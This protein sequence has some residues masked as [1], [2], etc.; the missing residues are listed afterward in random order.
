MGDDQTPTTKPAASRTTG[1]FGL[2]S[3]VPT[4]VYMAGLV[5]GVPLA[6]GGGALLG[7]QASAEDL[8]RL[9]EKVDELDDKLDKLAIAIARA[10]SDADVGD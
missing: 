6:G 10:H 5:L 8:L 3:G 2:P 9:E 1:S 7:G 4:W